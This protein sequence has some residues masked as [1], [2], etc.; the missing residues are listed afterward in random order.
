M[1]FTRL[2]NVFQGENKL[3]ERNFIWL[4]DFCKF[5]KSK[6]AHVKN[7]NVKRALSSGQQIIN[8]KVAVPVSTI[9]RY[10]FQNIDFL[11]SCNYICNEVEASKQIPC[12]EHPGITI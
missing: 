3:S 6:D 10:S 5:V 7:S 2:F 12:R 11:Q 4:E 9:L 1:K 8:N